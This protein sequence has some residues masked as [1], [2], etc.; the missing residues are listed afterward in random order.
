M[1]KSPV[2]PGTPLPSCLSRGVVSPAQAERVDPSAQ[3][4]IPI[5][6]TH[7]RMRTFGGGSLLVGWLASAL[8]LGAAGCSKGG[9][10]TAQNI[11]GQEIVKP[12]G[13]GTFFV[14]PN[15]GGGASRLHLSQMFWA[16]VVDVHDIDAQGRTSLQPAFRDFTINENIQ[17]DGTNYRLETN[18]I[19]QKARLTILRQ[20][21]APDVGLGTFDSLLRFAGDGLPAVIPKNDDGTSSEP[22]S[23]VARNATLVLIF[24][25]LLDDDEEAERSLIETVRVRSG[26]PAVTPFAARQMF[27]P[28]HGD[29]AGGKFHSTRVLVDLTVSETESSGMLVP[30]PVNAVGLPPSLPTET[31]HNISVRIPTQTA[32]GFGQFQILRGLSGVALAP[33]ENGPRDPS[34]PTRDIV[35][36]MR[37]GGPGDQNNGFMLDLAPPEVVGGWGLR[38][39]RANADPSGQ[40]GFDYRIDLTF[41][42][43]CRAA[44]SDGDVITIGDVFLEVVNDGP[45]PDVDG[46]V[47][48]LSVRNLAEAPLAPGTALIGNALFLSTYQPADPVPAGCWVSFAPQPVVLPASGVSTS[49][50]VL[51]RFSEAMDPTS[52]SPFDTFYLVRGDSNTVVIPTN[53]LVGTIEPS[54]DLKDFTFSPLLELPH[55]TNAEE[56]YHVRISG[57]TDLAGNQLANVLPPVNFVMN[58]TDL[59]VSN[60]GT[61]LRFGGV[62]ELEPIGFADLRGQFFFDLARGVIRPRPVAFQ[63]FPAD[64]INPVP[65][66]MIPFSRGVQTPLSPLGSKLQTMWR[67]A[68]LGWQVLDETKFN[69]DVFG[70][71]WAP[72]G[73][74]I[75]NDFYERFEIRLAHSRRMP[76]EAIDAFLLPK[77]PNSG[78]VSRFNDNVLLDPLSPQIIAHDRTLQYRLSAV[79]LFAASSGTIMLPFPLNRTPG[80]APVTYTWRD[81]SLFAKAGPSG[82][83]IPLDIEQGNPLSLEAEFGYVAAKDEVPSFGLPLLLEFRCFPSNTGIGLNSLDLSLAINSSAIPSF[84]AYTTGGINTSGDA[85]ERNPDE[86]DVARGG[87]NPSSAPPGQRTA[88]SDDNGF[89]VGQLDTVTRVSRMHSVWINTNLPSPDYFE[90][91]VL[92]A[93]SEQPL[94]TAAVLEF[95]GA[96]SFTIP[97]VPVL[98]VTVDESLF[99]F[100]A[101]HLNPYG[102]VFVRLPKAGSDEDI[103]NVLGSIDFNGEIDYV[104]GSPTWEADID[105]IDGAQFLQMRITFL[106]NILTGLSPELSAIALSYSE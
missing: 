43:V 80:L 101:Q 29:I 87:F 75:I 22:F 51:A 103:Y 79:D 39:D 5:V 37:S 8:L 68:D 21:G 83:G 67:Y 27:D 7:A 53:L 35:R 28:N 6:M 70:L 91:V 11:P 55:D 60:G 62:D 31:G 58:K 65:S 72:V 85:V 71:A 97:D 16:R 20:R 49:S 66:I 46:Q 98:G 73:G 48:D 61:V 96:H 45:P 40:A 52:I 93:A 12:D 3:P 76:D 34:G 50:V 41:Q 77:W 92:P 14:D 26:Y 44:P 64:R 25:D 57:V 17:S 81:T 104:T 24:D 38:I 90:P 82:A 105:A 94:G 89:Y 102:D 63:S 4:S 33:F 19:T 32:F 106:N 36:A 30:Q 54:T 1:K 23:F 13:S 74:Q 59:A 18:P 15:Q 9:G 69:L 10:G 78:L 47:Q 42:T 86:E 95:R 99:P 88:R 2:A 56:T 100:D 84:R